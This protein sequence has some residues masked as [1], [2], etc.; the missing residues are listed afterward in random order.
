MSEATA[1]MPIVG[2]PAASYAYY[3]DPPP[4][5]APSPSAVPGGA[6]REP[7]PRALLDAVADAVA[8]ALAGSVPSDTVA[9]P[10][11]RHR[12]PR[13]SRRRRLCHARSRDP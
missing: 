4:P 12:R 1:D 5:P 6:D 9:V 2:F 10:G 7:D 11:R 8:V 13:R 3:A